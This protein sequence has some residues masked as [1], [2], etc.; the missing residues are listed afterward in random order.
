V[1]TEL[2]AR[3]ALKPHPMTLRTTLVPRGPASR[4]MPGHGLA[5][6]LSA[7]FRLPP[8]PPRPAFPR[9]HNVPL[10]PLPQIPPLHQPENF[11]PTGIYRRIH[12]VVRV[13]PLAYYPACALPSAVRYH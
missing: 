4:R 6:P 12:N 13:S 1:Y 5:I 9:E 11:E 10:P 2:T 8:I 3:I 7:M